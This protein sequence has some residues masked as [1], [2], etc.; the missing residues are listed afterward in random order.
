MMKCHDIPLAIALN[1]LLCNCY[2]SV[3]SFVKQ[4][5]KYLSLSE[6]CA[7]PASFLSE[8]VSSE[9]YELNENNPNDDI[10]DVMLCL[11]YKCSSV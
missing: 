7:L 6:A 5:L 2:S 4:I 3:I 1:T 10:N 9:D 8:V 11:I